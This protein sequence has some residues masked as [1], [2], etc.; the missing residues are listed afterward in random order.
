MKWL[1]AWSAL[2]C[3]LPAKRWSDTWR[4]GCDHEVPLLEPPLDDAEARNLYLS[5]AE[6]VVDLPRIAR[7]TTPSF[8]DGSAKAVST[9]R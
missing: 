6:L 7:G 9:L 3:L 4:A 1:R 8:V 2:V 5:M